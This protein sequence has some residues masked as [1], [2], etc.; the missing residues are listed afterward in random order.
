MDELEELKR[1]N[2]HLND[3]LDGALKDY[4]ELLE[5]VDKAIEYIE[6]NSLFVEE[7]DY[8]HEE[9]LILMGIEDSYAKDNLLEILKGD[10]NE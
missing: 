5:R 9:E 7:Y 2:K 3:L 8:N 4:D 6:N 1:D 10:S